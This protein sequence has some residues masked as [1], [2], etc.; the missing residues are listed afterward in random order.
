MILSIF[1]FAICFLAICITSLEKHLF[2]SAHLHTLS[3][4]SCFD[5]SEIDPL[6]VVLF[7]IFFFPIMRGFFWIFFFL[8]FPLLCKGLK[9]N[10]VPFV[11]FYFHILRVVSNRI[12]LW[13]MSQSVLFF[14][15]TFS[16]SS[17]TFSFL[18]SFLS[19]FLCVVLVS[20]LILFFYM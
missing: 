2:G 15:K 3:Y 8:W 11:Y 5:I 16:V 6:S 9:F 17:F 14:S 18:N 13:L 20:I 12:L 10:S 19:L 7:A 4:M 1:S